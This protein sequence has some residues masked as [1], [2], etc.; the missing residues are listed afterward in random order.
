MHAQYLR[1]SIVLVLVALILAACLGS[2]D[3]ATPMPTD[4]A[5]TEAAKTIVAELTQNAPVATAT[6]SQPAPTAEQLPSTSTP[7]PT[8][9]PVPTLPQPTLQIPPTAT[10]APVVSQD[11]RVTFSDDFDLG[12]SGWYLENTKYVKFGFSNGGYTI[13]NQSEYAWKVSARVN[14]N[15]QVWDTRVEVTGSRMKGSLDGFYGVVCN[16]AD[17]SHY[18]FLAVSSNGWY[19]I[20]KMYFSVPYILTEG[21]NTSVVHTGNASNQILGECTDTTLTLTVNGDLLAVVQDFD[22]SAGGVGVMVGTRLLPGYQALFD[23]FK[24]SVLE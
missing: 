23:N 19:G 4:L 13:T 10:P 7:L 24:V 8:K 6:L 21:V 11:Y 5:Y 22:L 9:T 18:Y 2:T 1:I 17:L 14:P 12:N 3:Q 20:G 16:F 15:M